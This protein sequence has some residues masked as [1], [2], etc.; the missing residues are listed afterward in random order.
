MSFSLS[1]L[2][3]VSILT[4]SMRPCSRP[5]VSGR[6]ASLLLLAFRTLRGKLHRQAGREP[7]W[8][9][10]KKETFGKLELITDEKRRSVGQWVGLG[11]APPP[12]GHVGT[13][14]TNMFLSSVPASNS[15]ALDRREA[16]V[17]FHTTCMNC[18]MEDNQWH[19]LHKQIRDKN[20]FQLSLQISLQKRLIYFYIYICKN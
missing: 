10:L 16:L 19:N 14:N 5:M 11:S 3:A 8:F 2:V 18:F 1:S 13:T 15:A 4:S 9:R 17:W 7:S 6:L 12:R 20:L